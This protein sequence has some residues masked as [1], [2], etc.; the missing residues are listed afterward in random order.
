MRCTRASKSIVACALTP[1]STPI[2]F[3]PGLRDP[4]AQHTCRRR[5][6]GDVTDRA[7]A[8]AWPG[9]ARG[10]P[11]SSAPR[12]DPGDSPPAVALVHGTMTAI[13]HADLE[14]PLVDVG[15]GAH[16]L[17]QRSFP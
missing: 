15:R 1:P 4:S 8:S 2:R 12:I 16:G 17:P 9:P 11:A 10:L 14:L 7:P 3:M 5:C 13:S 6:Y